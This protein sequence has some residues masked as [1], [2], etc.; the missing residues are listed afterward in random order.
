MRGWGQPRIKLLP[1]P[2]EKAYILISTNL[3]MRGIHF[4]VTRGMDVETFFQAFARFSTQ[5]GIPL[6]LYS[7]KV[8]NFVSTKLELLHLANVMK[9]QEGEIE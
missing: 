7:D 2:M 4:E 3:T 6:L 8:T 9:A 1:V 5:R